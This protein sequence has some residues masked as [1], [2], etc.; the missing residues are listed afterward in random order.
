MTGIIGHSNTERQHS[1]ILQDC[2]GGM[3][4]P[5]Y[6]VVTAS[7][8][9]LLGRISFLSAYVASI[10]LAVSQAWSRVS[11]GVLRRASW[12]CS[13]CEQAANELVMGQLHPQFQLHIVGCDRLLRCIRA[14]VSIA[15]EAFPVQNKNFYLII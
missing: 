5:V 6:P 14:S 1:V 15:E 3:L 11:G 9:L 12:I 13:P 2:S 7:T 8:L 10:L 4:Y